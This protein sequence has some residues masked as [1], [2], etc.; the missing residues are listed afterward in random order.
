MLTREINSIVDRQGNEPSSNRLRQAREE[1]S[2]LYNSE[3]SYWA[4]RSHISWI[5]EG[6]RNTRFFH[7]RATCRARKN[8]IE[9]L[10]DENGRLVNDEKGVCELVRR[11]FLV[12]FIFDSFD[13]VDQVFA[14]IPHCVIAD[15]SET[16]MG[17]VGEKEIME[18]MNQMDSRKAPGIDGLS[19]LF[20]K[21]HWNV[22]G[23]D[24]VRF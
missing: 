15:M 6:D 19:G 9:G 24:V 20:F 4:Q 12:L 2:N 17:P 21:E 10:T 14:H 5:H 1:L 8:R 22:V 7:V 13:N 16:L 11:Y 23:V 3:E 18:A